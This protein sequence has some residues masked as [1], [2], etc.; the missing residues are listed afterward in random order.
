MLN[1][2]SDTD[3]FEET[4]KRCEDT[5]IESM[6]LVSMMTHEL[7]FLPP[8]SLS[9][10]RLLIIAHHFIIASAP[11]SRCGVWCVEIVTLQQR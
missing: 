7:H 4:A 10:H 9:S 3:I 2:E 11:S 5:A 8:P 6:L 1:R